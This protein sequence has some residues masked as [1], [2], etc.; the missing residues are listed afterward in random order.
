MISKIVLKQNWL[1]ERRLCL[2]AS[3]CAAVLGQNPYSGQL[4][5]Y[6]AKVHEATEVENDAMW[7]GHA[8]EPVIAGMITRKTGI[9]L[10]NPGDYEICY[11]PQHRWLG[12]TLDRVNK[13]G[14][15]VELK[16]VGSP[17]IKAD[18]WETCPPVWYQIQLQIQMACTGAYHGCLVGLFYGRDLRIFE[19]DRDDAFLKAAIPKLE[20]FWFDNVIARLPPPSDNLPS[21][22]DVVKKVWPTE[23]G[24]VIELGEDIQDKFNGLEDLKKSIRADQK[25]VKELESAVRFALKNSSYGEFGDGTRIALKTVNRKAYTKMVEA[26]SYRQL[27][28]VKQ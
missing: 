25:E 1:D 20:K 10:D 19:A 26:S 27:K 7:L 13:L 14:E 22:L 8:M 24:E 5:V 11:H 15:P 3:D 28:R 4:A 23:N 6:A 18:E 16:S 9:N 12:A 2:G 17:K 21:T